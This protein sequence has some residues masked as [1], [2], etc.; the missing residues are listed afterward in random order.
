[1]ALLLA[2][3]YDIMAWRHLAREV[4]GRNTKLDDTK[5]GAGS[6]VLLSHVIVWQKEISKYGIDH[7]SSRPGL[8][9]EVRVAAEGEEQHGARWHQ[10]ETQ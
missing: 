3:F 4:S 8:H 2:F 1:M 10:D 7:D 6:C 9:R 5:V